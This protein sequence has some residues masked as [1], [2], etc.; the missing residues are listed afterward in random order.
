MNNSFISF[1]KKITKYT[2]RIF[3]IFTNT[4]IESLQNNG[5]D[6]HSFTKILSGLSKFIFVPGYSNEK[7]NFDIY[8]NN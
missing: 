5:Y 7:T 4:I 1:D 2:N 6:Y 8:L 3:I